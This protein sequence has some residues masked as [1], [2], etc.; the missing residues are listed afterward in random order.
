MITD[1][2]YKKRILRKIEEMRFDQEFY[3]REIDEHVRN[4]KDHGY[5]VYTCSNSTF[6]YCPDHTT[7]TLIQNSIRRCEGAINGLQIAIE[8]LEKEL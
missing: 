7:P 6:V 1:K 2:T 5:K 3:K 4:A 8:K